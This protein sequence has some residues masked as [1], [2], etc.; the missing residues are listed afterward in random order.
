MRSATLP[1]ALAQHYD[2]S[3][4]KVQ[5]VAGGQT[6]AL[7]RRTLRFIETPMAHWPESM[8]TYLPEEKLLFSMD[9]FGQHYATAERFDE[10]VP[11]DVL[12]AEAKT[13]YANIFMPYGR[14][15]RQMPD[16]AGR[17]GHR[18]DRAQSRRPFG[19][20]PR[21]ELS[22]PIETGS[23]AGPQRRCWC[24][25]TPMWESTAKMAEAIA[26]AAARPGVETAALSPPP[27]EPDSACRRGAR[28][29]RSGGQLPHAQPRPDAR[30]GRRP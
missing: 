5:V 30:S 18:R 6:I 19:G 20:G 28:R 24:S 27:H 13:Y 23:P 4:W 16:K 2:I 12:M 9:V 29:G 11:A 3:A 10:E 1:Q 21:T 25:T 17:S 14:G 26:A 15:R 22:P 8:F 7:G